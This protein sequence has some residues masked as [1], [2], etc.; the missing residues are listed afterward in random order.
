MVTTMPINWSRSPK[1][2]AQT[3]SMFSKLNL[4]GAEL[5]SST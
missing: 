1:S 2:S 4:S 3:S 5:S